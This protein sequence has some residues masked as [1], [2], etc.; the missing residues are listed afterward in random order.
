MVADFNIEVSLG[1]LDCGL[2]DLRNRRLHPSGDRQPLLAS[3][4]SIAWQLNQ[5]MSRISRSADQVATGSGQ[6]VERDVLDHLENLADL[7]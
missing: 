2:F 4:R 1:H 7:V 6:V 5:T 3:I